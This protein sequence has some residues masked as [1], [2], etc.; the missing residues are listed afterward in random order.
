MC[1]NEAQQTIYV[2]GFGLPYKTALK[3]DT[4]ARHP[5]T[6]LSEIKEKKHSPKPNIP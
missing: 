4:L 2:P 5:V 1:I 3:I 6:Q